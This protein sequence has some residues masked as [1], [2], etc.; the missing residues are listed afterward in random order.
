M[1]KKPIKVEV[2]QEGEERF[3]L[4]I[5]DDGTETRMPIVNAPKKRPKALRPYWYWELRTG[6][7]KFF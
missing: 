3:L 5:Y 1:L 4:K 6:R 2:V 7:R